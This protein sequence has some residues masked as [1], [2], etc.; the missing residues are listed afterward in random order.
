M[1]AVGH[2]QFLIQKGRLALFTHFDY[3]HKYLLYVYIRELRHPIY[4]IPHFPEYVQFDASNN[5][6]G[7]FRIKRNIIVLT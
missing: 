1:N 4:D 3:F 5:K 7:A 2:L 6:N